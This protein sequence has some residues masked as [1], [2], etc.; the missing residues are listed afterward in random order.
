MRAPSFIIFI[1]IALFAP[2]PAAIACAAVYAF[3]FEPL[4]LLCVAACIDALFGYG[5]A[6]MLY[7]YTL[8]IAAAAIAAELIRPFVLISVKETDAVF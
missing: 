1:L 5:A 7:Q 2:F 3:F 6:E 4:E 8:G